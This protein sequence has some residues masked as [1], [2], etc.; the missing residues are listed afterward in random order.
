MS[1]GV[2]IAV[3]VTLVALSALFVAAEFAVLAA[4]RHRLV[5]AAPTSRSARAALRSSEELTILL[6]A[7]QLGITAATLGLGAVTKP[8]VHDWIMPL[9]ESLP[10]PA[11]VA[12][13][14]SF[15]LAMLVVTFIHLVVGEM[16]PKSWALAHPERSA[17]LLALP[18]RGFIWLTR[19]LLVSLNATANWCLRRVRVEPADQVASGR[20]PEDLRQLV[21]HSGSTGV[22]DPTRV[23]QVSAALQLL[24]M[25]VGEV[26]AGR[27]PITVATDARAGAVRAVAIAAGH[28]RL[29]VT[30]PTGEVVGMVHVRDLLLMPEQASIAGALRPVMTMAAG[31]PAYRALSE[32]RQRSTQLVLVTADDHST[33]STPG[34]PAP[35]GVVTVADL[36]DRLLP[37]PTGVNGS[38][39]AA[40]A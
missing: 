23:E 6:A 2:V 4:K 11:W 15:A 32:M 3:T 16:A 9:I 35:V 5:A 8:A 29:L 36:L 12:D 38:N 30:D 34:S 39:P 20:S 37:S 19:P 26:A 10:V 18:M 24:S 28:R 17:T 14:A 31:E 25:T 40:P 22:L 13:A 21:D 7:A 27:A 33:G 1:P